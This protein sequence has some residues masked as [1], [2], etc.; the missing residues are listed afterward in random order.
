MDDIINLIKLQNQW[1]TDAYDKLIEAKILACVRDLQTVG[2]QN[3]RSDSSDPMIREAI[4][5]FCSMN[6]GYPTPAEY[7]RLKRA[8][9]EIK[10][11][12]QSTSG[13]GLPNIEEGLYD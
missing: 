4:L 7:D 2:I 5:T 1:S 13:Y 11:Q 6:M 9:D 10:A 12:L 3:A 8:Y